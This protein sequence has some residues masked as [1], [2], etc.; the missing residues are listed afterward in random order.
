MNNNPFTTYATSQPPST[1]PT[2]YITCRMNY[3]PDGKKKSKMLCVMRKPSL[4]T[5]T[6]TIIRTSICKRCQFS[7]N[8]DQCE[9]K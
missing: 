8:N 6:I 2:I 7:S 9:M 5:F 1:T 4:G 3:N